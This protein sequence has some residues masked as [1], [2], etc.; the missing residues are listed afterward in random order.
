M[1]MKKVIIILA[2]LGLFYNSNSQVIYNV[3]KLDT[4][5]WNAY[6]IPINF[7]FNN[8]TWDYR[9]GANNEYDLFY[10]NMWIGGYDYSGNLHISADLCC[11]NIDDMFL[12]GPSGNLANCAAY[13]RIWKISREQIEYHIQHWDE[14]GYQMPEVIAEWPAHGDAYNGESYLLAPFVDVNHNSYYDPENGDYPFIYGDQAMFYIM[15]DDFG[16]S[17][18]V[19]KMGVEVCVMIYAFNTDDE[20]I[21]NTFFMHF[22][23]RNRSGRSYHDVIVSM[24]TDFDIGD[25]YD[26]YVGCDESLNCC[27][28][29]TGHE[30]DDWLGDKPGAA[31]MVFLSDT[32]SSFIYRT[33]YN[34]PT[35]MP[36]TGEEIYRYMNA[37]WKDGSPLVH[38]G[39]GYDTSNVADS[40]KYAFSE[41]T[42]WRAFEDSLIGPMDFKSIASVRIG[43]FKASDCYSLDVAYT[44]ARDTDNYVNVYT[45]VEKLLAQVP[46]IVQFAD[47]LNIYSNCE[48]WETQAQYVK[49]PVLSLN[50]LPNPA[51]SIIKVNTEC[52]HYTLSVYNELGMLIYQGK[53]VREIDVSSWDSGV[54][55]AVLDD[56][57]NTVRKKVIVSH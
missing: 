30:T 27:F 39:T 48:F 46:H 11:D 4:N 56:G 33:E 28:A 3:S 21:N 6:F 12:P 47:S 10:G 40:C 42:G 23:I 14:P 24:H 2:M 26:D 43:E 37:Y 50:I 31:G 49:Y 52:N 13:N 35:G 16:T 57:T 22:D 19:P 34:N 51:T 44:W 20:V 54:Y 1:V 29:Y 32:M 55:F 36:H 5:N 38:H 9:T 53:D 15:S 7:F 18:D 41:H 45:P 8:K 17:M 25:C